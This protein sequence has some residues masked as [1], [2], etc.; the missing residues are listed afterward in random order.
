MMVNDVE[1]NIGFEKRV[2][3]MDGLARR[4]SDDFGMKGSTPSGDRRVTY[5]EP[6]LKIDTAEIRKLKTEGIGPAEIARRLGIGR[7]SAYRALETS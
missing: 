7:A 2:E 3:N 4:G 5:M 6:F 1:T